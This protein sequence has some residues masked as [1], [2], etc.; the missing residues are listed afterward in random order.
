MDRSGKDG[1]AG[2]NKD[3]AERAMGLG[4]RTT[5]GKTIKWNQVFHTGG[6]GNCPPRPPF[7]GEDAGE[8]GREDIKCYQRGDKGSKLVS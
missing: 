6:G 1:P 5:R 7:G 8:G 3:Q 4:R 2:R